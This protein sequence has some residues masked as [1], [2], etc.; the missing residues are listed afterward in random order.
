MSTAEQALPQR[1]YS[2]IVVY[3]AYISTRATVYTSAIQSTPGEDTMA[4]K[5]TPPTIVACSWPTS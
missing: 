3:R 1:V 2:S 4:V 5:I